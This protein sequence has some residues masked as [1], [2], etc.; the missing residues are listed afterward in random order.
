MLLLAFPLGLPGQAALQSAVLLL[1]TYFWSIYRPLS[2]PPS[3]AF[4]LGLLAD[5]LGPEPPGITMLV[6]V[7]LG[8][9]TV[10]IRVAVLRQ[11]F[12]VVW[13]TFALLSGAAAFSEWAITSALVL[14]VQTPLP[15]LLSWGLSAGLYPLLAAALIRLH[16]GLAAPERA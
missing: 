4:T 13:L 1:S 9:I 2:M 8:G 11:G 7:A 15:A 6:L 14:R 3:A 10:R 16:R 12:L 5:L